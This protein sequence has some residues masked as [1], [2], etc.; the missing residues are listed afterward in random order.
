MS[1][2]PLDPIPAPPRVHIRMLAAA[3]IAL[4]F[5]ALIWRLAPGQLQVAAYKA[6]L[7]SL[8]VVIAYW[9]DRSIFP[10]ARPHE[11]R[12]TGGLLYSVAQIRRAIIVAAV[13][14]AV[15]L[16]A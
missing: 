3:L 1:P 13:V 8:A 15:C 9:V 10:Y 6:Y 16:G 12:E 4:A 5:T 11:L 7:V 14:L 2:S